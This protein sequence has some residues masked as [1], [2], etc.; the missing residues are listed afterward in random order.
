MVPIPRELVDFPSRGELPAMELTEETSYSG[1]RTD[2]MEFDEL[3]ISLT[4]DGIR[5]I[6][7]YCLPHY[8]LHNRISLNITHT[9]IIFHTWYSLHFHCLLQ[10]VAIATLKK[11][12]RERWGATLNKSMPWKNEFEAQ[13][14]HFGLP[15]QQHSGFSSGDAGL[16]RLLLSLLF[17]T[18]ARLHPR[19]RFGESAARHVFTLGWGLVA[20]LYPAGITHGKCWESPEIDLHIISVDFPVSHLGLQHWKWLHWWTGECSTKGICNWL[21]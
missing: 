17:G 13:D 10:N 12:C 15:L 11:T 4:L 18:T 2:G 21:S 14:Y 5:N 3:V 9:H 6:M 7:V 19:F 8:T 16:D 1:D 20:T